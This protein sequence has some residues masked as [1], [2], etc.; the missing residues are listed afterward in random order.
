MW[1]E[2]MKLIKIEKKRPFTTLYYELTW[3]VGWEQ[4]LSMTNA[5]IEK[6]FSR[7]SVQSLEVGTLAGESL[8]NVTA[9]LKR[10]NNDIFH[11]AAS[12]TEYGVLAVS[13]VSALMDASMRITFWNQTDKCMVQIMM[14]KAIKKEGKHAYDKYMDSMELSG[15]INYTERRMDSQGG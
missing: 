2:Y 3:P 4:M 12:K 1:G 15:Y 14:D 8:K 11:T 13:G 5:I 7:L 9:E 10:A 6:D